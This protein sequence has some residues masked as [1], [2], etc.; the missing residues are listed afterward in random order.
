MKKLSRY[1]RAECGQRLKGFIYCRQCFN[2]DWMNALDQLGHRKGL[3]CT[4][5]MVY[6]SYI[7]ADRIDVFLLWMKDMRNGE[8]I[9]FTNNSIL[10]Y[11]NFFLLNYIFFWEIFSTRNTFK[12]RKQ[13][14]WCVP[15]FHFA[16]LLA[17]CTYAYS[18]VTYDIT[19]CKFAVFQRWNPPGAATFFP[20][21]DTTRRFLEP[22]NHKAEASGF[23]ALTVIGMI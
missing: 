3:L 9:L 23:N 15:C 6:W 11:H 1:Y 7:L 16:Y 17:T 12:K 13:K 20:Y 4:V 22:Q 18:V 2:V 10:A 8:K 19:W 5:M 21:T 14:T